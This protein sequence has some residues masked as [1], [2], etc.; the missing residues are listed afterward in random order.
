[1]ILDFKLEV[2]KCSALDHQ[3]H[4]TSHIT[5]TSRFENHN[6]NEDGVHF[7]EMN[8]IFYLDMYIY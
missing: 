1:M 5:V 8:F 6:L 2:L 3:K 4:L 7:V